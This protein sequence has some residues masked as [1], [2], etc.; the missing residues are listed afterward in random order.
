MIL[1]IFLSTWRS[2]MEA[3]GNQTECKDRECPDISDRSGLPQW[4]QHWKVKVA[5]SEICSRLAKKEVG[6]TARQ[7]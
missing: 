3:Y 1:P 2:L 6:C 7:V 4:A 5:L